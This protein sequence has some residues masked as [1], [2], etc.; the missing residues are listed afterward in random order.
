MSK[1]IKSRELNLLLALERNKTKG[2][3]TAGMPS[4]LKLCLLTAVLIILA[5][6]AFYVFFFFASSSLDEDIRTCEEYLNNP[7]VLAD[8]SDAKAMKA[9]VELMQIRAME[10]DN[11]LANIKSYPDLRTSD[12]KKIF[13]IAGGRVEMTGF[14]YDR[15]TGMLSF[16]ASA[17]AAT[18]VPLFITELRASGIFDSVSYDGYLQASKTVVGTQT[19]S[20]DSEVGAQIG[21]IPDYTFNVQ[22]V[23]KAPKQQEDA[24]NG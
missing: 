13:R 11:A 20:A 1:T 24:N 6:I 23:V 4:M 10:L 18:R 16:T 12:W 22:C 21:V 8:Y 17:G 19:N 2:S 3:G 5:I 7:D 14:S 15:N 9:E